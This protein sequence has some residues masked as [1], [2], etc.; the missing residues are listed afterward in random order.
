MSKIYSTTIEDIDS[1]N[2]E[3]EI[4]FDI[5]RGSES[6]AINDVR[7]NNYPIAKCRAESEFL[8]QSYISSKVSIETYH[9][10]N[11]EIGMIANVD[12]VLYKIQSINEDLSGAKAVMTLEMERW[13]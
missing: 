13:D 12:S 9:I 4:R 7:I 3:I 1:S 6:I 2:K 8:K 10:D 11:V 5:P